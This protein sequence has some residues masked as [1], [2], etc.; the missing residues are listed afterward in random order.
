MPNRYSTNAIAQFNPLTI[1]EL[2][3]A[4]MMLRQRHDQ[5]I[6]DLQSIDTSTFQFLPQDREFA[7]EA[8]SG[9]QGR[10]D[11]LVGQINTRGYSPGV[12]G[13]VIG[14]KRDRANLFSPRGDI[15]RVQFQF[16]EFNRYRDNLDKLL[17]T[18]K[19][20][21]DKHRALLNEA[22]NRYQSQGGARAG[23]AF[24][25]LSAQADTDPTKI[26]EDLANR[27]N[28]NK[29]LIT[30]ITGLQEVQRPDG[31]TYF[32]K[33]GTKQEVSSKEAIRQAVLASLSSNIDVVNDLMQRSNLGLLP[34]DPENYLNVIAEN[35]AEAFRVD[36]LTRF[37]DVARD[38]ELGQ[39]EQGFTDLIVNRG[40]TRNLRNIRS[41]S[42]FNSQVRQLERSANP[43]DKKRAIEL[44]S[45]YNL[46]RTL[47]NEGP[48]K[49]L[50][51]QA[52]LDLISKYGDTLDLHGKSIP[53]SELIEGKEFEI[54]EEW[55]ENYDILHDGTIVYVDE[56]TGK[57]KNFDASDVRKVV[58]DK[59]GNTLGE[60]S[61]LRTSKG[62]RVKRND[63]LDFSESLDEEFNK[64]LRS[65]EIGENKTIQLPLQTKPMQRNQ[66]NAVVQ[67]MNDKNVNLVAAFDEDGDPIS[68]DTS[69][70]RDIMR[71]INQSKDVQFSSIIDSPIG[72]LPVLE[73]T[74]ENADGKRNTAHIELKDLGANPNFRNS[75]TSLLDELSKGNPRNKILIDQVIDDMVFNEVPVTFGDE[76][77][78]ITKEELARYNIDLSNKISNVN[79]EYDKSGQGINA[80]RTVEG[81]KQPITVNEYIEFLGYAGTNQSKIVIQ[82]LNNQI[83]DGVI[84]GSE[85]MNF[86]NKGEALRVI[87]ALEE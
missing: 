61:N 25:G 48:G 64:F 87:G 23:A 54:V 50:Q 79:L 27:I 20:S 59:D 4:P 29:K 72:E 9:L 43:K 35:T 62:R 84:T 60:L 78:N 7:E 31:S 41:V 14:L 11:D 46:A 39:F 24:T 82:A 2:S 68:F 13:D 19:I 76:T 67:G 71:T 42:D 5:S 53:T 65:G 81:I 66:I 85:P 33:A 80:Y 74:F 77:Y 69:D 10:I 44:K 51:N 83:T 73:L 1:Q 32:V 28:E 16:D 86:T 3:L 52:R 15:G 38:S 75:I 58:R 63:I 45:Q 56:T 22:L 17:N 6:A 12:L 21:G 55:P 8:A 26:A 30:D 49:A 37:Q 47:F 36:Q 57:T 34:T 18:N 70:A 40:A